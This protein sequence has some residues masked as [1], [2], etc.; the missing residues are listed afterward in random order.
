MVFQGIFLVGAA[1]FKGYVFPKTLFA[2]ILFFSVAAFLGYFIMGDEFYNHDCGTGKC[3]VLHEIISHNASIIIQWIF[4][5]V[6][7][8][9]CWLNIYLGLK[10]KEV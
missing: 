5:W 8:P 4:W 7:A 10:E 1:Y 9:V 2:L 6:L 3:E